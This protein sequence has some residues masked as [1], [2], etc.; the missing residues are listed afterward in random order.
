MQLPLRMPGEW[1]RLPASGVAVAS[2]LVLTPLGLGA[3]PAAPTRA[4][5]GGQNG[6]I[7]FAETRPHLPPQI[8]VVE[9]DGTGKRS[10]TR[11]HGAAFS[12]D[13][14]R[15]AYVKDDR[16]YIIDV[17]TT[18]I[19]RVTGARGSSPSWSPDGRQIV[20][21]GRLAV[22]T[23]ATGSRVSLKHRGDTPSWSP[24][25]KRIAFVTEDTN[26]DGR[27]QRCGWSNPREVYTIEP[28]GKGLRQLT[29]EGNNFNPVWS[30][31]GRQ[32]AYFNAPSFVELRLMTMNADGSAKRIVRPVGTGVY[33]WVCWRAA[34]LGLAWSPDGTKF[35]LVTGP[36][37]VTLNVDGSA[38]RTVVPGRG[39]VDWQ[40]RSPRAG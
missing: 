38:M 34:H 13:G 25:G 1:F 31:D 21:G 5:G 4:V 6:L 23:I 8:T 35:A 20:V 36:R 37:I 12:P 14:H 27:E 10:L 26:T 39:R 17:N 3:I 32:I 19:M 24:T 30:P 11:G 33:P 15:I 7:A 22:T 2:G 28:S 9:P 16:I 29:L 18:G 40:R